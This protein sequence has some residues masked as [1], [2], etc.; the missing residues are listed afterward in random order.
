MK[1]PGRGDFFQWIDGAARFC[2]DKCRAMTDVFYGQTTLASLTKF[3]TRWDS[4]FPSVRG[5]T[6]KQIV[7]DPIFVQNKDDGTR[8]NISIIIEYSWSSAD[9]ADSSNGIIDDLM[10]Q[11]KTDVTS[12]L[13]FGILSARSDGENLVL[14]DLTTYPTWTEWGEFGSC[15][16]DS[17]THTRKKKCGETGSQIPCIE[18][19]A[20]PSTETR[21]CTSDTCRK[22]TG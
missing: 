16:N 2:T 12:S 15:D 6:S 14:T 21:T 11:V 17:C 20:V 8:V 5:S 4:T 13:A 9:I 22:Y 19:P 10:K 7:G 1:I 3:Y 18:D